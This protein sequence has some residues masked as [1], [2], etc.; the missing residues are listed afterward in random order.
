MRGWQVGKEG[1]CRA[2]M[3][4]MLRGAPAQELCRAGGAQL[5]ITTSL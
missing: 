3:R 2:G 1:G 4:G 5:P